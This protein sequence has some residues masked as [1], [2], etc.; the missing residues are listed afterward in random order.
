MGENPEKLVSEADHYK[1]EERKVLIGMA[2]VSIISSA[3]VVLLAKWGWPADLIAIL[4]AVAG[5]VAILLWIKID[6]QERGTE[7]SGQFRLL[8]IVVAAF[9]LI[10]YLFRSRGFTGGLKSTGWALLYFLGVY[11]VQTMVPAILMFSIAI[12]V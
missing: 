5:V 9:A 11:S 4:A 6:C 12:F 10:Y 2:V 1:W 8:I 3:L 7:I